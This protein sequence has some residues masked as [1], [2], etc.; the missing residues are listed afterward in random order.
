MP[1]NVERAQRLFDRGDLGELVRHAGSLETVG[2]PSDAR[3]RTILAHALALSGRPD[4]AKRVLKSTSHT[5]LTADVHVRR[6]RRIR[7]ADNAPARFS[8][9]RT[10]FYWSRLHQKAQ[11]MQLGP[12]R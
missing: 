3:L 8:N 2:D 1:L 12:R 4:E 11:Q 10:G 9:Q 7:R 6:D 5:S